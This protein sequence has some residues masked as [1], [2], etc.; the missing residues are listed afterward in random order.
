MNFEESFAKTT[1]EIKIA[2][3]KELLDHNHGLQKQFL[4]YISVPDEADA[5]EEIPP[6]EH[7][8]EFASDFREE[9][10]ALDFEDTDWEN[11]TPRHAGYIP[12]YEAIEH[13]AEDLVDEEFEM[14]KS[15]ILGSLEE[16]QIDIALY[17]YA[18]AYIACITATIDDPYEALPDHT[19][20]FLHSLKEIEKYMLIE[21]KKAV[22]SKGIVIA[23]TKAL[24]QEYVLGSEEEEKLLKF[25]EP[26]LMTLCSG[27]DI[28]ISIEN[29]LSQYIIPGSELPQLMMK[30][31]ALKGDTHAWLEEGESLLL[32]DKTVAEDLLQHYLNTSTRDFLRTAKNIFYNSSFRDDFLEFFYTNVDKN[33]APGFYKE[34]LK[35]LVD[36]TRKAEY[37]KEL[38]EMMTPEEKET[39]ISQ[40]EKMCPDFYTQILAIENR[41]GE[42]LK[43]LKQD[44]ILRDFI[45]IIQRILHVYPDESFNMLK[46][47]CLK[48]IKNERGR[49]AYQRIIEYL[50]LTA[51]IAEKQ[52][53]VTKLVDDLYNWTPRLPALRDELKKAGLKK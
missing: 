1:D 33:Q 15:G 53:E 27:K 12:E 29:L 48:T 17:Q 32:E 44:N 46:A 47:K 50:K 23:F 43:L 10:E 4:D 3:L 16:G 37:Y 49:H 42:I 25:F 6:R 20:Y 40:Y 35:V 21:L 18:G 30:I 31:H 19:A 39:F 22:V 34:N 45:S 9:L 52:N 11:Y 14:V 36:K 13:M 8:M 28:A 2:F 51:S 38:R 26:V 7:I 24:F 5:E 41:H